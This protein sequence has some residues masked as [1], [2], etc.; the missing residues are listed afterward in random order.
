MKKF[1]RNILAVGLATLLV[2]AA[3]SFSANGADPIVA[4]SKA[5]TLSAQGLFSSLDLD[6]DECAA[7]TTDDSTSTGTGNCGTGL[8][9]TGVGAVN[10]IAN[11]GVDKDNNG[12]S[13]AEASTAATDLGNVL[14]DI[15][16]TT[17]APGLQNISTGT[18]LD[19]VLG[20]LAQNPLVAAIL[21]PLTD[22]LQSALDAALTPLGDALPIKLRLGATE[23]KCTADPTGADGNSSIAGLS[24]V[25]DLP[26]N[27]DLIIPIDVGTAPNSPI[28]GYNEAAK[29]SAVADIVDGVVTGLQDTLSQSFDGALDGLADALLVPLKE[30]LL[31][32]LLDAVGP[33]LL[34]PLG[35]LLDD[36]LG[37]VGGTVNKQTKSADGK[38]IS[39]QT[40]QLH[41]LGDANELNI[42]DVSCGPNSVFNDT[43][44]DVAVDDAADDVA[45]DDSDAVADAD[46]DADADAAADA[47]SAA[48]ADVTTS[49]PNTGA[50]ANLLPFWLLGLALVAFGGAVLVN[51]RR[52]T[53]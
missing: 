20:P 31:K 29:S 40:L 21:T 41:L 45:A 28:I 15:D 18:L 42:G 52:R 36:T 49:L 51:E 5:S 14:Q 16:L 46:A 34:E 4:Q 27:N 1:G 50:S 26:G 2:T 30:Q 8:N 19:G 53:I 33:A 48:D 12:V 17:L 43:V 35:N 7:A 3:V 11:A 44:D 24:V 25:L 23:S 38:A 39:V 6:S 37:V 47:D 13:E 22:A 9:V 10:Q 32:P